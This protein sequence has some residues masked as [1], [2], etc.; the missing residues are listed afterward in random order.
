MREKFSLTLT[1]NFIRISSG[2]CLLFLIPTTIVIVLSYEKLPPLIPLFNSMPWGEERLYSSTINI[3][4]P[5]MLL[6]IFVINFAI[7]SFIYKKFALVARILSFNSLLFIAL[8]FLAYIQ[9][10]FLIF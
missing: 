3:F 8:A 9:I 2:L 7:G 6:S 4:F 1:D 10:L 5:L